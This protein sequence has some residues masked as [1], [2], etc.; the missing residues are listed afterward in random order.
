MYIHSE[1]QRKHT[2]S[3]LCDKTIT[4]IGSNNYGDVPIELHVKAIELDYAPVIDFEVTASVKFT[5]IM[6]WSDHPLAFSTE[7]MQGDTVT[8][9]IEDTP[10]IRAMIMELVSLEKKTLYTSTDCTY[11]ARLVKAIA[12]FWS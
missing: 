3:I 1:W 11:R 4:V 7:Y 6:E 10:C 9:I 5:N 12:S 8:N 2:K